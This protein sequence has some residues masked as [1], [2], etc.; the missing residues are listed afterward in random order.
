MTVLETHVC[1]L[2][3]QLFPNLIPIL[4]GRPVRV[5]LDAAAEMAAKGRDKQVRRLLRRKDVP[6]R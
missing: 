1:L 2:T 3:D 4:M 6:R 5:Y